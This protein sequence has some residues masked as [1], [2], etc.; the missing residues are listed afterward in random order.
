MIDNMLQYNA[1]INT[2]V[3]GDTIDAGTNERLSSFHPV[4]RVP[5]DGIYFLVVKLRS[6][7]SV[8]D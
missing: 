8:I 3:N 7:E 1:I 2:A 4:I 6:L 5:I